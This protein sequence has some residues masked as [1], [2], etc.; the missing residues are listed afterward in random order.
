MS[1]P[2]KETC[3]FGFFFYMLKFSTTF[4]FVGTLF[5]YLLSLMAYYK[6]DGLD[7]VGAPHAYEKQGDLMRRRSVFGMRYFIW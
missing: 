3:H 5:S 2:C 1:V 4:F 6:N 7:P